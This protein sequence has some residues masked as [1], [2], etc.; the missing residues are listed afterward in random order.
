MT[1]KQVG[2]LVVQADILLQLAYGVKQCFENI[3]PP[4]NYDMIYVFVVT[5]RT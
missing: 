1:S 2:A 3:L 5:P 4:I